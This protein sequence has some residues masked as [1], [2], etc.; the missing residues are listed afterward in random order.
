MAREQWVGGI[1]GVAAA[2]YAIHG[3]VTDTGAAG[4]LNYLQQSMMGSYSMKL[5]VLGLTLG[6][7]LVAGLAML[8]TPASKAPTPSAASTAAMGPPAP[9][10]TSW[11][12]IGVLT[13]ALVALTWAIGYGWHGWSV[14]TDREDARA[15]YESVALD[16][17]TAP[18]ASTHV[19]LRGRM[20]TERRVEFSKGSGGS[21]RVT[22]YLVPV[23]GPG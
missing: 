8:V 21:K 17:A 2:G 20:L 22:H 15:S 10:V 3:L 16:Q 19:A 12:S 23:V 5:T 9:S 4:W 18:V 6:V 7:F 11:R 1:V 13:V 14:R